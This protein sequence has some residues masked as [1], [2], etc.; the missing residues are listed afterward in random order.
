MF[1]HKQ[2]GAGD[3]VRLFLSSTPWGAWLV[4]LVSLLISIA[5]WR[6]AL[7][8]DYKIEET[9]FNAQ[10][11]DIE[12]RIR[13]RMLAY[14]HV[15]Q[16]AAGLFAASKSVERDEW[17]TYIKRLAVEKFYPGILGGGYSAHLLPDEKEGHIR[18]VHKEGFP[19][20]T[21]FPQGER[22]EYTSIVYLEPFVGRNLKA[23]GFD[24]FSESVRRAA[25]E[26]ARDT[27]VAA[28]SG[29]VE[30]LKNQGESTK[31]GVLLYLPIYRNGWPVATVEQRRAALQGYVFGPFDMNELM[32][33]ILSR[34]HSDLEIEVYDGA[35]V[36]PAAMLYDSEPEHWKAPRFASR[37]DLD[38]AGQHWLLAV[39]SRPSSASGVAAYH[40]WMILA[41]GLAASLLLFVIFRNMAAGRIR[42]LAL[43]ERMSADYRESANHYRQL[44][45]EATV[46]IGIADA[47]T[48]EIID[49]NSAME[50]LSG[51]NK[52]ELIGKSQKILHPTERDPATVSGDFARHRSGKEGEVI[53]TQLVTKGGKLR[54]VSIKA[55]TMN[56][57][58]RRALIGF[59]RDITEH[60]KYEQSLFKSNELMEC[61]FA[62]IRTLLAYM[63]ADFNFIRVNQAYA[64]ADGRS[65]D[66][67]VGK[68]HFELYPNQENEQIFREV[69]ASGQP[70][71]V[72]A[73]PFVYEHNQ[74]RKVSY[75]DWSLQPVKDHQGQIT[76]LL[77]SLL[78]RTEEVR[79]QETLRLYGRALEASVN[80]IVIVD[81][82]QPDLPIM[83]VN[84]AFTNTTGYSAAEA[85]GRNPRFLRGTD[86]DQPEIENIRGAVREKRNGQAVL[87]NY[88][89]DGS[90][91]W[92][93]LYVSPVWG[94]DGDVT[95]FIG[96][97]RDISQR[98]SYESELERMANFDALTE[99]PNRNLFQDRLSQ[100]IVHAHRN[101]GTMAVAVLDLDG[102]KLVND[103][104][105]HHSGDLLLQEVAHRL[106]ACVREVDTV[107]R[108]GGDEFV[109]AMPQLAKEE[110][111][112]VVAEKL[113]QV[114]LVAMRIE[115]QDVFITA[116]IGIAMYPKDG[117]D[118][119]G[120]L[121]H[122]DI[123]MYRAKQS[124]RNRYQFYSPEMNQHVAECLSLSNDM[125]RALE[126]N[127]F[128]LHYQPQVDLRSGGIVGVE[129]LLRWQHPAF[130]WLSPA[131]FIPIAE[132]CGLIVSIGNW[133]LRQA[134]LTAK[135]WHKQGFEIIMAVN[136]SASQLNES[137]FVNSVQDA[138]LAAGL[139]ARYLELELTESVLIDQAEF[140]FEVLQE[141]REIGV[142]LSIDD[143]G[144]GYSSLSYLKRFPF[145]RLKIDQSFIRDIVSDPDDAAIVGAIISMAHNLH[146]KVTAE[147]VEASE[148]QAFL[149]MRECDEIQ[150][151]YFSEPL[152]AEGITVMLQQGKKIEWGSNADEQAPALLLLDDEEGILSA[153]T[154]VLRRDGYR[155]LRTCSAKEALCMLV[156][157]EVGV[158]ISDQ[159]MPEMSG[160]DFLRRAKQLHPDSVRM[161]L[162]GYTDLQSV[163]DAI[164]EG[165]VYKFLTKPWD[166][167]QL[168]GLIREAFQYY[169]MKKER[170]SLLTQLV[171]ANEEL[172]RAK[173]LLETQ[174]DEKALESL[175]NMD[176]L[177]VSQEVLECLPAGVVGVDEDGM[178]VVA[179]NKADEILGAAMIGGIAAESLPPALHEQVMR[180]MRG[181]SGETR[182]WKTLQG[183]EFTCWSHC[184]GASSQAQ[185]AVLVLASNGVQIE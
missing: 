132:E 41:F 158:I 122:A 180:T 174:V 149:R 17:H 10:V 104:L 176:F 40:P 59:F 23:F 139:E 81:A 19:D 143:F 44:F 185:G 9:A 123:A 178:I 177:R 92:N 85:L 18:Q 118:A 8:D 183:A 22:A 49:L 93:E 79:A 32:A 82:M 111:A 16:G 84:P 46:A 64:A 126:R 168:R 124:G 134:C 5:V 50:R 127:E 86:H 36:A 20:Y 14:E 163:T 153:L 182:C 65:P 60:K 101:G 71:T 103:S 2:S 100:A 87:L 66:D 95:H 109:I 72:L 175:R 39:N 25:M 97:A 76:G 29:K 3:R 7:D 128:R 21:I 161:V 112:V 91:F 58:G 63:D 13:Q 119:E 130:G 90:L 150:G 147:G 107:A 152:P 116:S 88:R 99:L 48:G 75:W 94:D 61:I 52:S 56:L 1:I 165:A 115:M 138:L 125:H 31:P 78:E 28:L 24:M 30:L 148:Q 146:L 89:K 169:G 184:M 121:K 96:V 51:W 106:S 114:F 145:C 155:I 141:L 133:V 102:F 6:F 83:Y 11:Q 53:E 173:L 160:V 70:Y 105:G 162:S 120:L 57:S 135:E 167:E 140:V 129:A 113:L 154:R 38:V 80:T 15:L 181:G 166:D 98:K 164:N 172:S 74:G 179:N 37:I 171:A 26:Q 69:V 35:Q 42:A 33:G 131:K 54:E 34:E 117:T 108:L 43:A 170:D 137:G 151:Y 136:L 159:R 157:N 144:T 77:L 45:E 68:N 156:S 4:L 110:D 55:S 142:A 12:L 27:G 47:E 73:K 62:N 67:L